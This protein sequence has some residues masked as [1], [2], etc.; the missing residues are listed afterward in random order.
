MSRSR[1][2]TWWVGCVLVAAVPFLVSC[3]SSHDDPLAMLLESPPSAEVEEIAAIIPETK[4]ETGSARFVGVDGTGLAY[5][6]G[7]EARED[8]GE[9][10]CLL[11]YVP[12]TSRW[13]SSCGQPGYFSLEFEGVVARLSTPAQADLEADE[14]VAEIVFIKRVEP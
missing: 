8:A 11:V 2:I 6:V 9:G 3:S 10:V 13:G 4:F 12:T 1:S 14:N 7:A 5:Y